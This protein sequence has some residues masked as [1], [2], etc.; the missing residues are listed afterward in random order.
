MEKR[1]EKGKNCSAPNTH[2]NL[3]IGNPGKNCSAPNA[4]LNLSIGNPIL[5]PV[6]FPTSTY[7]PSL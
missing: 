6:E 3:S 7:S 1:E 2:L 4:H 5:L